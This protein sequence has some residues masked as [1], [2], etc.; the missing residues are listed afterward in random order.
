MFV[1][2]F[3][4]VNSFEGLADNFATIVV[5]GATGKILHAERANDLRHPASL[6]K[7][8]TLYLLFGAL[9]E[10]KIKLKTRFRVSSLAARQIPSKLGLSVGS[11]ITVENII[12]SLITKSANDA[13]IVAAEGLGKSVIN[14]ARM[15]NNKARQLGMHSTKFFNPS[16]VPD[17]RQ[18]TTAHDMVILAQ[19]IYQDFPKYYHYFKLRS[20]YYDGKAIKTHNN[21]LKIPGVDG[22]KTGYICA[23][24]FNVSTSA[25]RYDKKQKAH[26]LFVV[27]MG[28][29]TAKSRDVK[30]T[31]LLNSYFPK[32]IN[33]HQKIAKKNKEQIVNPLD[34][35]L[36]KAEEQT[37][38][39]TSADIINNAVDTLDPILEKTNDQPPDLAPAEIITSNEKETLP[40]GWV[41]P[42]RNAKKIRK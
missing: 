7:K 20:F 40:D 38:G 24:G 34:S 14:F 15:M 3:L 41:I 8:M 6:T 35:I 37:S 17:K 23:S 42:E 29:K 9:D 2:S 31:N 4:L 36:N 27:V 19:A 25:I 30:A 10:G 5:D 1:L 18:V 26:R 11:T 16:G 39:P 21:M 12:K 13:A 22:L 32:I 33:K 28:G